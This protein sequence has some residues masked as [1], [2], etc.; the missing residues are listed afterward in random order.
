MRSVV[1]W[2]SAQTLHFCLSRERERDTVFNES[3]IHSPLLCYSGWHG[4]LAFLNTF[5]SWRPVLMFIHSLMTQAYQAPEFR[6]W[7]TGKSFCHSTA[8]C[9][10]PVTLM[11]VHLMLEPMGGTVCLPPSS[12]QGGVLVGATLLMMSDCC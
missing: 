4:W 12:F 7:F 8:P 5:F 11:V 9:C 6:N 2:H 3:C 10:W 1:L